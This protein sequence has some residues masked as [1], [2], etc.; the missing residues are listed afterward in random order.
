[1]SSFPEQPRL[2]FGFETVDWL[3]LTSGVALTAFITAVLVL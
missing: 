2:L 3:F 1:M